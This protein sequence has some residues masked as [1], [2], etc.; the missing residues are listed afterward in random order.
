MRLLRLFERSGI[1]A[2]CMAGTPETAPGELRR[3]SEVPTSPGYA[4]FD[5]ETTGTDPKR[6]E[7]V[8][9]ALVLLDPDGNETLRFGS[10]IRPSCARSPKRHP[11]S[12]GFGTP[13]LPTLRSSPNWRRQLLERLDGR[14]FVAH[15]ASFD[16]TMLRSAFR[17][18]GVEYRPP[19][20]CLHAR[21]LPRTRTARPAAPARSDL[22]AGGHP[23]RRRT[24]CNARRRSDS[25]PREG[26]P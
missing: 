26:A 14:V 3:R 4:V 7:I 8:S 22:L 23:A 19:R 15:N 21:R 16:L 2:G 6:D 13:T 9:F 11:R 17:T 5:C 18:A 20:S 24:P 10:L 12:T 25:S 1:H